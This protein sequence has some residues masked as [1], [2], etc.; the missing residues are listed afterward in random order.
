MLHDPIIYN[1]L[2]MVSPYFDNGIRVYWNGSNLFLSNGQIIALPATF[3]TAFPPFEVEGV[4]SHPNGY[5]YCLTQ[6][7]YPNAN[8]WKDVKFDVFDSP[9]DSSR[10]EQRL[11][12]LKGAIKSGHPNIELVLPTKCQGRDH[13]AQLQKQAAEQGE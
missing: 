7:T 6:L 9:K 5:K 2:R 3:A 1:N 4:L 12:K 11:E 8:F 13:L 10:L